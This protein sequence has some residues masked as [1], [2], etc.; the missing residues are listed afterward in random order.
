MKAVFAKPLL[1]AAVAGCLLALSGV[2]SAQDAKE[3]LVDLKDP[4]KQGQMTP[5]FNVKGVKDKRWKPKEWLE[6]EVPFVAS[7][8]K[9]SKADV[10]TLDSLNFKYYLYLDNPDKAKKKILT[11]DVTHVNVP[12]GE[13][14]ASVVYLSPA[15]IL[16]LTGKERIDASAVTLWAVEV[17][18]DG[19]MVGFLS[20]KGKSPND[21]GAKW[22][23]ADNAPPQVPG[24]LL[25]KS[26]T[27]FAP[28]WGDYHAD[29]QAS[30]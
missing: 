17:T 15:S 21:A 30:K 18:R 25:N 28:L 22:W 20:S 19:A 23:T 4:T 8:P 24:L 6:F 14:M 7:A 12:I 29:V 27:P 5:D 1:S 26:Q 3:K 10:K 13:A 9:G 11:A 2:S 16:S